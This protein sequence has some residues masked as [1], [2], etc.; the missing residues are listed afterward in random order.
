MI[1]SERTLL[2]SCLSALLVA[3]IQLPVLAAEHVIFISVDG[4]RPDS[5]TTLGKDAAPNF[6]RL[7]R[8]GVFTDNARTD[9]DYT[10][11]LPNHT[12]MVT[13]RRVMG[14]EGHNWT[15]NK[16]PEMTLHENKGSYIASMFDVAHDAGLSTA[17]FASKDKF[18]LYDSS[19][20]E[21][22]GADNPNGKDKLDTY[23]SESSGSGDDTTAQPT[24]DK[25][26]EMSAK[27]PYN[28]TMLHLA[29]P[30]AVGHHSNWMSDAYL[31]SV[32]RVDAML[33][34]VMTFVENDPNYAGK[35]TIILTADHGGVDGS[36]GNNKLHEDYTIPFYVWGADVT[37]PGDL[38]A[39]NK[40]SR[41]DPG[42]GRPD[43]TGPQPIRNGDAGNLCL[44]LLGLPAIPGSMIDADQS[45]KVSAEAK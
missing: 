40:D 10:V 8:E 36:H 21:S 45:L 27:H 33:G 38:Y 37:S 23:F 28:L 31:N 9:Y 11:T 5:V 20:N 35:T 3:L 13:S 32:K 41:K 2:S 17:M 43:Y 15:H 25:L 44:T 7:R 29:D 6:Y 4:M 24:V 18:V 19:Y 39:V 34:Q 22:N 16:M 14:P 30:D 42:T 26:I 12:C 1:H